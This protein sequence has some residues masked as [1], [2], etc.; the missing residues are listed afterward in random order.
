MR[1]CSVACGTCSF[2][3]GV[4]V[5]SFALRRMFHVKH[6]YVANFCVLPRCPMLLTARTG[7]SRGTRSGVGSL[8][9]AAP[10]RRCVVSRQRVASP[11]VRLRFGISSASR[12]SRM[13]HVK[14]THAANFCRPRCAAP[15]GTA[16]L[17]RLRPASARAPPGP[18]LVRVPVAPPPTGPRPACAP[19]PAPR[20]RTS[21]RPIPRSALRLAPPRSPPS[22][23][24]VPGFLED[25]CFT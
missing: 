25:E 7:G 1:P 22:R 5:P 14:H 16:L 20:P 18:R 11:C 9:R 19:L 3:W 6:S 24:P 13:F 17:L 8:G 12:P 23:L 2:G 4:R 10:P 21:T 15:T